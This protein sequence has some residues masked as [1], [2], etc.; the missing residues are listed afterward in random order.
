MVYGV[1][2][3]DTLGSVAGSVR[4]VVKRKLQRRIEDIERE[5]AIE[6]ERG[7]IASDIHD[8]LGAGLTEIVILSELAQNPEGSRDTVQAD[9]S[10]VTDKA[11]ALTHSLDEIVW[12]VN[13]RTTRWTTSCLTPVTLPKTICNR[14][15]FA[16]ASQCPPIC[17]M[18]R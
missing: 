3:V 18:S 12:A 17:L 15:R 1:G 11:R 10:K 9:I 13:P 14:R 8:D 5:R 4:Y 7:R 2:C 6:V 16:V